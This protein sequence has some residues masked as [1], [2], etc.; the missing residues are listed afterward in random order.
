[1]RKLN[2]G[3]LKDWLTEILKK[4]NLEGQ[5]S[6]LEIGEERALEVRLDTNPSRVNEIFKECTGCVCIARIGK[7]N[8]VLFLIE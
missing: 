1:M 2:E 7:I 5:F 8:V 6:I 3:E 4:N